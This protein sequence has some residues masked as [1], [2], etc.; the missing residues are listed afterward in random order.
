MQINREKSKEIIIS[1]GKDAIC[2]TP[3]SILFYKD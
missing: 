2:L 3:H 1:L